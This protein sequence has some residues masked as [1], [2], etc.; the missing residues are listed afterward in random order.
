ME[1]RAIIKQRLFFPCPLICTL[2]QQMATAYKYGILRYSIL[3]DKPFIDP[4]KK[5]EI[6][7]TAEKKV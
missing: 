3:Q 4:R 2:S 5:R 6:Q 7:E 1:V